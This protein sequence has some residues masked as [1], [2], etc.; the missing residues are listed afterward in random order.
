MN[1]TTYTLSGLN[2]KC[3]NTLGG[4]QE[5]YIGL[6]TDLYKTEI[7]D[8]KI[9][10]YYSGNLCKYEI[11]RNTGSLMSTFTVNDNA[12]S[13]FETE[14]SLV[15]GKM[16]TQKR[17]EMMALAQS[18]V[19]AIVKDKN[20]KYY[21][22]GNDYPLEM[23]VGSGETGLARQDPN[24]YSCTLLSYSKELPYELTPD[25]IDELTI[26]YTK[27]YLTFTAVSGHIRIGW[28]NNPNSQSTFEAE[29]EYSYDKEEWENITID[30]LPIDIYAESELGR[31]VYFRGLNPYGTCPL[32][33]VLNDT[34]CGFIFEKDD[35]N[36]K[37]KI[38]GNVMSLVSPTNFANLNDLMDGATFALLFGGDDDGLKGLW[39]EEETIY[40]ASKLVLPSGNLP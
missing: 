34:Y 12:A 10:P 26:D 32:T 7:I 5:V 36:A 29:I 13:L 4:I 14:L 20:G 16:N 2:T 31:T 15:F 33:E 27:E 3:K 35:D 39:T 6:Y 40:D 30:E 25:A 21:F 8:G 24:R 18:S 28:Y 11:P 9:K 38:S 1:C 17:I 22:L 37:L 19:F 23:S